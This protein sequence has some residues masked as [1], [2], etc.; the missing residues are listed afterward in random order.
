[1]IKGA[2]EFSEVYSMMRKPVLFRGWQISL[3]RTF[4]PRFWKTLKAQ[5]VAFELHSANMGESSQGFLN[6]E[7]T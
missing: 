3:E 6:R 4:G 7:I 1:M 5:V 2:E